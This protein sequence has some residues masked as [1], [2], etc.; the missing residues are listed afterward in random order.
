MSLPDRERLFPPLVPNEAD[1]KIYRAEANRA[2]ECLLKLP[3]QTADTEE[4]QRIIP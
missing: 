3:E 4:R 1:T 2:L